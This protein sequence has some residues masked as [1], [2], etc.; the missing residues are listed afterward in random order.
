MASLGRYF[1]QAWG[2]SE[3]PPAEW[4]LRVN[5]AGPLNIAVEKRT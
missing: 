2:V 1:L 4:A 3:P 5:L